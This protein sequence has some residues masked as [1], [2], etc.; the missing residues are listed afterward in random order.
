[1]KSAKSNITSLAVLITFSFLLAACS[2]TSFV[3]RWNDPKF[4]GPKLNR[5]LVIGVIKQD[6]KR[7]SFEQDFAS[8][9][10]TPDR[11][12]IAS[13]TLLPSLKDADSKE[14]VLAAVKKTG[15]DGVLIVTLLGVSKEK[16]DVPASVD[17][18]PAYGGYDMYGYY[19]TSYSRIY[20]PG[21]TVTN[22]TVS[23]ET[24]LFNVANEKMI[25]AGKTKS[26]NSSSSKAI[27]KELEK[28]VIGDMQKSGIIK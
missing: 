13:Y 11:K 2:S 16:V 5:I 3:Q 20:R 24:L 4:K 8:L 10:T 1:M 22:T 26:F 21:Y 27:I 9:I 23:I 28:L 25:W 14:D 7:R 15:A 12:G 18:Y 17:Y 6:T 19:G